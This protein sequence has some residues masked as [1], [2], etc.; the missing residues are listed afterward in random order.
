MWSQRTSVS[1]IDEALLRT[2]ERAPLTSLGSTGHPTDFRGV[3]EDA[4]LRFPHALA[5]STPF[6]GYGNCG[7]WPTGP[8]NTHL[9]IAASHTAY[10]Q[11]ISRS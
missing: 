1:R 11:L 10:P 3:I 6:D 8:V 4:Q 2:G 9:R 7:G 5:Y